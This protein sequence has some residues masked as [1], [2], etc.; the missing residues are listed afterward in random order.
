MDPLKNVMLGS[1]AN[2]L[3]TMLANGRFDALAM[4]PYLDANGDSRVAVKNDAG[5]Y[6]SIQVNAPATLRYDEWKDLD[7]TVIEIGV[8]RLVGI[9]DLQSRGLTHA[10]G[11]IGNTISQWDRQSGMTDA[12]VDMAGDTS[13]EEDTPA[14]ETGKVPV[15]I[16]HKDFRLNLRRLAASRA[17]GEGIDVTAAAIASRLVS[18]KSEAMLFAG[19]PIQVDGEKI[20][21][22]TTH[23]DR[24]LVTMTTAWSSIAQADNDDIVTDVQAMTA[25]ARADR[26][27]G[28]YVLYIP[29]A[30]QGK[31]DQDYRAAGD[32]RTLRQRLLQL[33]GVS[34]IKVADFLTGNNV[35]LVQMD[36]QTVDLATAQDITTVEWPEQGGMV[37][38]YKVMAIWVPRLKSDFDGRMGLVHLR[39]V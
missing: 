25:A 10:L 38:R 2:V 33:E 17:M 31:M 28:P 5:K 34:D 29:A 18:E 23:P 4:R 21:G 32:S 35:V 26:K 8:Q 1:A 6:G 14:F 20:Y 15:P 9:A 13:G 3:A 27:Y 7:R 12:T 22:Y 16:I 37:R 24:N 19:D 36:R 11:S 30:Y 39:P